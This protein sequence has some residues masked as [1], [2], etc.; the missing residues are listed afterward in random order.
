MLAHDW[1]P[2]YSQIQVSPRKV[3]ETLSQKKKKQKTK[4]KGMGP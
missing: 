3:S 1:N 4:S 2:N